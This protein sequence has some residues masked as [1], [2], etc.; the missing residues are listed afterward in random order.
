MLSHQILCAAQRKAAAVAMCGTCQGLAGYRV[1]LVKTLCLTV[2]HWK[3]S[4]RTSNLGNFG[5]NV[6]GHAMHQAKPTDI[7]D[8]LVLCSGPVAAVVG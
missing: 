3:C 7:S 4:G 5:V 1:Y 8:T 2:S 6:G